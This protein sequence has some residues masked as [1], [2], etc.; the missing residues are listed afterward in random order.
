MVPS[1]SL[2]RLSLLCAGACLVAGCAGH[3][4]PSRAH[5]QDEIQ[6]LGWDIEL[7]QSD[8]FVAQLDVGEQR[9]R[10]RQARADL[11]LNGTATQTRCVSA[12]AVSKDA[13]HAADG[14]TAVKNDGARVE[15]DLAYVARDLTSLDRD[16]SQSSIGKAER[17]R[18]AKSTAVGRRKV[19]I[20]EERRADSLRKAIQLLG[21]ID[22]YAKQARA[23]CRS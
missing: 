22:R 10:V 15:V 4:G 3:S 21:V 14:V 2:I 12:A 8:L 6:N 19:R 23:A 20:L 17:E 16:L 5:L 9:R 18:L 1:S 11:L 13:G 7:V